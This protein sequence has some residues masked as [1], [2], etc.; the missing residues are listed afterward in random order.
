MGYSP[1]G[2]KE[3]DMTE[4][5]TQPRISFQNKEV[6]SPAPIIYN[7]LDVHLQKCGGEQHRGVTVW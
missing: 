3:S 4:L 5:L 2:C 6:T 7:L 1:W